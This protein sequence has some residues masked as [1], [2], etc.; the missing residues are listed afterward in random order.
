MGPDVRRPG[1]ID[2]TV[3]PFDDGVMQVTRL[4]ITENQRSK[5]I[6]EWI[7][8]RE[9]PMIFGA[10]TSQESAKL[11]W[12]SLFGAKPIKY[13]G[14]ARNLGYTLGDYRQ[15]ARCEPAAPRRQCRMGRGRREEPEA[16]EYHR[17]T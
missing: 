6:Y 2:Q 9:T 12:R 7:S 15:P 5:P 13:K 4:V 17:Y 8:R 16:T 1:T 14:F 3:I 10:N 11:R